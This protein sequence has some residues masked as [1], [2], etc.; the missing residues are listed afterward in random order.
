MLRVMYVALGGAAWD[1]R[2][3]YW[4]V[5]MA[6][7]LVGVLMAVTSSDIKRMLAYSSIAHAGFLLLGI[8]A[9]SQQGAAA[10]LFYLLAYGLTTVGAFAVVMLVRG[11]TGEAGHL[12][13]WAGLGRRS[14]LLAG[15]F[16]LFLLALAGIPLTSGFTAKFGVFAAALSSGATAPVVV[17]VV[18]SAISAFFYLRVIVLMFFTEPSGDAPSVVVPGLGTRAAIGLAVV[19][20]ILLGVYPQ[21][22]LDIADA[23]STFLR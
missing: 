20:T 5:A 1:W 16:A 21:V 14:P 15:V 8:V 9:Y 23:S 2:P 10:T 6:T 18:A 13:H 17:A 3:A 11:P 12:S 4:V 22:A 7:M 19:A